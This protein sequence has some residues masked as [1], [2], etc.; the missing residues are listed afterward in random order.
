MFECTSQHR[1]VGIRQRSLTRHCRL[2]RAT[3]LVFV[4]A[5][6]ATLVL[7]GQAQADEVIWRGNFSNIWD[8]ATTANWNNTTLGLNP[9]NFLDGDDVTFDATGSVGIVTLDRGGNPIR[10]ADLTVN[11][12]GY[13]INANAGEDLDV[14]GVLTV[15]NAG[16]TFT[17]D[18]EIDNELTV[19]GAGNVVLNNDV[20]NFVATDGIVMN[21]TGTLYLNGGTVWGAI[22]AN[23]G[24]VEITGGSFM[25]A[26]TESGGTISILGGDVTFNADVTAESFNSTGNA[27]FA[28]GVTFTGTG[29]TYTNA[30]ATTDTFGDGA[31]VTDNGAVENFGTLDFNGSGFLTADANNDDALTVTNFAGGIINLNDI[32]VSNDDVLTV[33]AG[34]ADTAF[35][36]AGTINLNGQTLDVTG[37]T[38][39]NNTGA[40]VVNIGAGGTITGNVTNASTVAQLVDGTVDGDYT[41]TGTGTVTLNGGNV[42]G[43]YQQAAGGVLTDVQGNSTIGSGEIDDGALTVSVGT[44]TATGGLTIGD[45]VGAA[46]SATATIDSSVAGDITINT[47]GQVT[48]NGGSAIGDSDAVTINGGELVL[49]ASETIGA[50]EGASGDVT[51]GANTLTVT[52]AGT[53]GGVIAGTGGLTIDG[54][55]ADLTLTGVNTYTGA[56]SV[57][58]GLLNLSGAITTSTITVT[59]D[60]FLDVTGTAGSVVND[61]TT[62]GTDNVRL[63]GTG[64]IASLDQNSGDFALN[65]GTLTSLDQ[66]GGATV[67]GGD[68]TITT[69]AALSGGSLTVGAGNTL[70]VTNDLTASGTATVAVNGTLDADAIM[71][72]GSSL[73]LA[74]G[75]S[76]D[77]NLSTAGTATFD[78]NGTSGDATVEVT[79]TM[80]QGST[81]AST[82]AGDVTGVVT[83][84]DGTLTVDGT[85]IFGSTTSVTGGELIV[86][87][88][89]TATGAITATDGDVTIN[90]GDSLTATG[91]LNMTGAGALTMNGAITGDVTISGTD[92]VT[93][94]L[95]STG[96]GS[97]TL[98]GTYTQN[99]ANAT[100][101]VNAPSG[102]I[103]NTLVNTAG[104]FNVASGDMQLNEDSSNAGSMTVD[105]TLILDTANFTNTGSFD[106]NGSMGNTTHSNTFTN[107]GAGQVNL[108]GFLATDF[109]QGGAT[110]QLIV[111]GTATIGDGTGNGG[112]VLINAGSMTVNANQGLT[113]DSLTIADGATLAVATG[114]SLFGRANTTIINGDATFADGTSLTDNGEITIGATGSA[115]FNTA[116]LGITLDAETDGGAVE[117]ITNNGDIIVTG[118]GVV[119]AN[120]AGDNDLDNLGSATMWLQ[121]SSSLTG[122]GLLTNNSTAAGTAGGTAAIFLE[123]GTTLGFTTLDSTAGM[124]V[125]EGTLDGD[126]NLTG[127]ADLDLDGGAITGDLNNQSTTE[128][129]LAGDLGGSFTQEVTGTAST[130]IDGVTTVD[131]VVTITT[132][133]LTNNSTITAD[134]DG[135]A[136][137]DFVIGAAGTF[138]NTGIANGNVSNAGATT[139][140]GTING[141]VG[142]TGTF[143][144]FGD[145]G[146]TT[147][148]NITNLYAGSSIASLTQSAGTTTV[149]NAAGSGTASI[150]GAAAINGGVVDIQDG[151]TLDAGS[152]DQAAGTTITLEDGSATGGVVL[153]T[154]G[155]MAIGGAVNVG[156]GGTVTS[157][158]QMTI[159]STG[160]VIFDGDAGNTFIA[161]I[162]SATSPIIVEGLLAIETGTVTAA[163]SDFDLRNTSAVFAS[164]TVDGATFTNVGAVTDTGTGAVTAL[165]VQA[166]PTGDASM[167]ATSVTF[168]EANLLVDGNANGTATLNADVTVRGTDSFF[169][170]NSTNGTTELGTINGDVVVNSSSVANVLEGHITGGLD[171]NN[172]TVTV[173]SFNVVDSTVDGAIT[174]DSAVLAG[175]VAS[176][177]VDF[178][179]ELTAGAGINVG[180]G[181]I[182]GSDFTDAVLDLDGNLT[183]DITN[184]DGT[185]QLGSGAGLVTVTGSMSQTDGVATVLGDTDLTEELT[186][187]GGTFTVNAGQQLQIDT[188]NST[189][190]DLVIDTGATFENDGTTVAGLVSN[191]GQLNN[192]GVMD[193]GVGNSGGMDNNGGVTGSIINSGTLLHS[194]TIGI[195][196]DQ[197]A[198]SVTIDGAA[199]DVTGELDV[200]GGTLLV[201]TGNVLTVGNADIEDAGGVTLEDGAE[202]V[203]DTGSFL[204]S[205]NAFTFGLGARVQSAGDFENEAAGIITFLGDAEIETDGASDLINN[206][207]LNLNLDGDQTVTFTTN[208][209][210]FD[211]ANGMLDFDA[212]GLNANAFGGNDTVRV[213]GDA[214]I[215]SAGIIDMR[216]GVTGDVFDVTG[217]LTFN[218]ATVL[219][220]VNASGAVVDPDAVAASGDESAV[221]GVDMIT[222]GGAAS[223]DVLLSFSNVGGTSFA[224]L[225]GAVDVLT[226]TGGTNLL[227]A[228]FNGLPTNGSI[229]Y[230]LNNT[231]NA[232]Q[233]ESA[234]NTAIGGLAA[235]VAATQ[236]LISSVVNRPSSAL[237]TPLVNPGD[238]P[239]AIGTWGRTSAGRADASL[240][241]SSSL[242]TT[243]SDISL[244]YRGLQAGFDHSCS[245]GYYNGW[246]IAFGGMLGVN[247]GDT[248][249]PINFA[250]TKTQLNT[251]FD[252]VFGG[253]YVSFAKG[254]WFGDVTLRADRTTYSVDE[255]NSFANGGLGV[256]DQEFDSR[257]KT[258]SGSLSY[259]HTLSEERSIRLV[260][261]V[262]FSF[263]NIQTDS[264]DVEGDPSINTGDAT[265]EISDINQRIGYLGA[266]IAKTQVQPSGNAAATYF[267][268]GTYFNDFSGD[269]ESVFKTATGSETLTSETLGSFGELS[270]GMN[271][272]QIIDGGSAAP[273]RQLDAS[274][275]LDSRF[276]DQLDSWG[277]TAQFRLQF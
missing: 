1:Q 259:S 148:S 56:T 178:G 138:S 62:N 80:T 70:T 13:I 174:V 209:G 33:S 157:T 208:T 230:S 96:G 147:N 251:E 132:G 198:G 3:E 271:W 12:D 111:D 200:D 234:A 155:A 160:D 255:L 145:A 236:S 102:L 45:G 89:L 22:V 39:L 53:F 120:G 163:G 275:R 87:A 211:L 241:S 24:A 191:A 260:P 212:G 46:D 133:T 189:F 71:T 193:G 11:T 16:D 246:D 97:T 116:G 229:V 273:A 40:G 252:Q 228:T 203:T 194:G 222:V 77:G 237:V 199:A 122:L 28:D 66:S 175:Q 225:G 247:G 4:L 207:T 51:L 183:G 60:G 115:T 67:V 182:A 139:N 277:L 69:V 187:N 131:E 158:G 50:L 99:N 243:T 118:T 164:L 10:T 76:V 276:S 231:G 7:S 206:G 75:G 74:S 256:E 58:A 181:N 159:E 192:D 186:V 129:T 112:T 152:L 121:D 136:A 173:T 218:N 57:Q 59:G 216:D 31:G 5:T 239:C 197:T 137:S 146:D 18:A 126:V 108:S 270:M 171:I 61:G 110:A 242:G 204:T 14:E 217:D 47:D 220:D 82:F 85:S 73:T 19:A 170:V 29:N 261:T 84:S 250:G 103:I 63:S 150:V 2:G 167:T 245:A 15:T 205:E 154:S 92:T 168:D 219:M 32:N 201:E 226:A 41:N 21:G 184:T 151:M 144:N 227:N 88:G 130:V 156:D 238:D 113:Y 26:L 235:G 104:N 30:A 149:D 258:V 223:G 64:T 25:Q 249:L 165:A 263:S 109:T 43:T 135:G 101:D 35:E 124:I 42:T 54:A 68:A 264:I 215:S 81:G 257:G 44:L 166:D 37:V 254:Q 177:V 65:G 180:A 100:T 266:T 142:N 106:L 253:T 119:D 272:T 143:D 86:D 98:A 78:V 93:H 107:S 269:V 140:T 202:I 190:L 185:V 49:G 36:N 114:G 195:D 55:T 224:Q 123:S 141:A 214:V 20:G 105:G 34:G 27:T 172:G 125:A 274:M 79:G 95:N 52:G 8:V 210:V 48:A 117:T 213:A 94:A 127:S 161:E 134:T 188:A 248:Q 91:G 267:L 233:L 17:V 232:V 196:L 128:I 72:G 268:T 176:L 90:S 38:S 153:T 83:V 162:S 244:R 169:V 9:D 221:D 240:S 6:G 265:L 23:S 179:I 262:G